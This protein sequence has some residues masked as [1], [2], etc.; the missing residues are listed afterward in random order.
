MALVALNDVWAMLK[1]CA[2]NFTATKTT[3]H[4]SVRCNQRT[5]PTLPLGAHGARHNPEIKRGHVR[6]MV[7]QLQLDPKCVNRFFPGLL[8]EGIAE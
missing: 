1:E 2:P 8:Q 3:H 6:Q 7:R 5:Y 4:Y